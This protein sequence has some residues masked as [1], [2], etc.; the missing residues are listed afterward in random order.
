MPEKDFINL[1]YNPPRKD[2]VCLF[3]IEP[4]KNI[5]MKKA[6]ANVALESSIG[7]WDDVE[8]LNRKLIDKLGAK[9]FSIKKNLVKIAYPI[10]LFELGNMP[11]VLSGIAG[12][13][14]GMKALKNLRLEDIE[15]PKKMVKSFKGPKYGI[16]GVRKFLKIK[17]RPLIGTIVKPKVGLSSDKHSEYAYKSWKGGL[18]LVKSDE[19]LTNQNFNKFKE[20]FK[21]T[22]KKWKKLKKKLEKENYMLKM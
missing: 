4:S 5:S 14:F 18:D 15:F 6:A 10:E 7:T 13:I 22:I 16:K 17:K 12:N 20:R 11:S 2:V 8:G 3:R 9:V 19:N 21:K 1:K